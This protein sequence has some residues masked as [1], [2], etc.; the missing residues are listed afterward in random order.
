MSYIVFCSSFFSLGLSCQFLVPCGRLS[1]LPAICCANIFA[2]SL[3]DIF[4]SCS[5]LSPV[6]MLFQTYYYVLSASRFANSDSKEF[7]CYE[8]VHVW[9]HVLYSGSFTTGNLNFFIKICRPL[10]EKFTENFVWFPRKDGWR[11]TESAFE[12]R[13]TS[14]RSAFRDGNPSWERWP[15]HGAGSDTEATDGTT[16]AWHFGPKH[17]SS[18]WTP[19]SFSLK[20]RRRP[21]RKEAS[22]ADV[23]PP[24]G[25]ARSSDS[26][27]QILHDPKPNSSTEYRLARSSAICF[28]IRAQWMSSWLIRSHTRIVS[29]I[30]S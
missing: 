17:L 30:S 11:R 16:I 27:E 29:D 9:K 6:W 19:W 3:R 2:S 22:V 12:S 20:W 1:W 24:V 21:R 26:T 15:R 23:S 25:G 28:R 7:N 10:W 14:D 8:R 18:S 5:S 13:W 4:A